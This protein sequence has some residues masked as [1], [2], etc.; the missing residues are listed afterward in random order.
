MF[1]RIS[2]EIKGNIFQIVGKSEAL[3]DC[4][5]NYQNISSITTKVFKILLH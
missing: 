2:L 3:P 5:I 4:I 1:F